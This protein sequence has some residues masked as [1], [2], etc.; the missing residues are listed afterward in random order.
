MANRIWQH[1][2]GEGLVRTPS[3]FGK[4]GETPTHPELL[5]YL[6]GRL[7][8]G[9]WSIKR[10][11]REIMLSATYRQS[12][13]PSAEALE[14]DPDNRLLARMNR[15]RLDAEQLRDSLLAASGALD[16]AA[17][18]PAVR[19]LDSPRR[20]LYV[21]TIR[22]DRSTFRDLFDGA[23]STAIVDRRTVSMVAPQALFML[24][25]S[26]VLAQAERLAARTLAATG[27]EDERIAMAYRQLFARAPRDEEREVARE[28]LAA[29]RQAEGDEATREAKAWQQYCQ[30]LLCSNEFAFVD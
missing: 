19:E 8:E 14:R 5:D 4:L 17:G 30:T 2:F 7:V 23:D 29:W 27:D 22:S 26:F 21:M 25:S 28:L 10:L 20:T 9:D 16:L 1:H 3:N 11:H 18:G 12:S 15:R 13:V 24:N 6:A